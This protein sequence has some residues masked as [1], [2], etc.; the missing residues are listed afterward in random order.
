MRIRR[1][2]HCTF[3]AIE[4]AHAVDQQ[5]NRRTIPDD[6]GLLLFSRRHT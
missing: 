1:L 3:A 6:G 2:R 4:L 5:G